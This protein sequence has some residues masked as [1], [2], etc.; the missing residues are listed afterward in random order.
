MSEIIFLDTN[1]LLDVLLAREPFLQHSQR[2]WSLAE[3]GRI[4]AAVSA[5]SFLNVYYIVRRLASRPQADRAVRGLRHLPDRPRRPRNHRSSHRVPLRR[6]RGRRPARLRCPR[7]SR[8]HRHPR[9][10]PFLPLQHPRHGPRRL[11]RQNR[12]R[13]NARANSWG[14][15]LST[16]RPKFSPPKRREPKLKSIKTP[17]AHRLKGRSEHF[18]RHLKLT[19][20]AASQRPIYDP[21]W[22]RGT[23]RR[24]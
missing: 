22:L 10:T 8:L 14:R 21:L 7:R 23:P 6:L 20:K 3:R 19:P 24:S 11:P 5:V 12:L 15:V 13:I 1:V 2:L 18:T 17:T 16:A 9:R 4:Q